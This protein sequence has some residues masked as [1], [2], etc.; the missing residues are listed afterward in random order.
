M[1]IKNFNIRKNLCKINVLLEKRSFLR[2]FGIGTASIF[3][4]ATFFP[5]AIFA[6]STNNSDDSFTKEIKFN[7][8]DSANIAKF[9]GWISDPHRNICGGYYL[10]PKI[11]TKYTKPVKNAP[12]NVS[13][14]EPAFFSQYGVS[15]VR[16]NVT[17]TQ[18]GR[19]ITADEVNIYHDEKTGKLKSSTFTG[20]VNLR[21][22]GKL[23]VAR[24]GIWDFKEHTIT[25]KNAIYHLVAASPTNNESLQTWGMAKEIVRDDA[26]TLKLKNASYSTCPPTSC[27]WQF[28]GKKVV[29]NKVEGRGSITHSTLY[30]H[31][32]PVF[33]FPYFSF[34]LDNRRKS[35][36]LYPSLGYSHDTGIDLA[37]PYYFN[38]APNYDATLTPRIISKRGLLAE[39]LFRY[40]TSNNQGFL[41]FQVI[42][43][44]NYFRNFQNYAQTKYAP[45]HQLTQLED[46]ST[47]RAAL[48]FKNNFVLD[49]HWSS[50]IDVNYVTDDYFMQDFGGAI[51]AVNDDQ[52][53]NHADIKYDGEHL[54]FLGRILGFQTLQMVTRFPTSQLQYRRTP[55][56]DLNGDYPS[57][58]G[59]LEYFFS[60]EFVNFDYDHAR[61]PISNKLMPIGNRINLQP[62]IMLPL[63]WLYGFFKPKVQVQGTMY[64]L[65]NNND[66]YGN[67]RNN[68][69]TRV[70]PIASL[71]T[72]LYFSR[73]IQVFNI[74]YKQTLEPR[75]FYLYVPIH[76]Q[77]DIPSFD[78]N[79]SNFDF[80]QLF[81]ENRF[82]GLDRLG[83]ANQVSLGLTTKFFDAY[84][85]EEKFSASVGAIYQIVRHKVSLDVNNKTFSMGTNFQPDPLMESN[86]SPLV[87]KIQYNFSPVWS[88][89]AGISWDAKNNQ[90][91]NDAFGLRY[92]DKENRIFNVGYNFVRHG[93][94]IEGDSS[95]NLNR[96]NLATS[97]PISKH[98]GIVGNLNYNISHNHHETYFYGIEYDSCCW[99]V[100]LVQ[101]STYSGTDEARNL[102]Y[103]HMVYFQFLLKGLGNISTNDAS[104]ILKNQIPGYQDRFASGF[105]M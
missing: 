16:G 55:Q 29:F 68:N 71:D 27:T 81:A 50:D 42:P 75:L 34:P 103:N 87:G 49:P 99:A 23:I 57:N 37:F 70:L 46:A 24:Q 65:R 20:H 76:N 82:S 84:S 33:Y 31:N 66:Q 39:G 38:L 72:G 1:G 59:N 90:A 61:D 54:H 32:M 13:A 3:L 36:F 2:N 6:G 12:I 86:L 62:G 64:N 93:D 8:L 22:Y 9:L 91:N 79:L 7:K 96:I 60:S 15:V 56:L 74:E 97:W 41:D 43:S 89:V 45:S 19:Q 104:D 40:L 98:F 77:D 10:E 78:S 48:A 85:S 17:I 30:V 28:R 26:G 83:D 47:T 69:I 92:H 21:E 53:L 18:P 5:A 88:A 100:R 25:L 80:D 105:K 102:Q 94:F 4:F 51:T 67:P 35:G 14:T 95:D 52:L 11:V 63:D 44:D 58:D 101:N 73:N